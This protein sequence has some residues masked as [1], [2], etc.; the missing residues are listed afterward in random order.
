MRN[1]IRDHSRFYFSDRLKKKDNIK[2]NIKENII[3]KSGQ[4]IQS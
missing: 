2:D 1:I 3:D 4:V